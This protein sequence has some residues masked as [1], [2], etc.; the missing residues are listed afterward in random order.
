MV[1]SLRENPLKNS[2][3]QRTRMR[4]T[5]KLTSRLNVLVTR[6][7]A[8]KPCLRIRLVNGPKLSIV[9]SDS[10]PFASQESFDAILT[11]T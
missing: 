11:A 2:F 5:W 1:C 4:Q 9:T 6:I 7:W 3:V 8:E 10:A